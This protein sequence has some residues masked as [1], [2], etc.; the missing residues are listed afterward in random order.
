MS[1]YDQPRG[2]NLTPQE[3]YELL[4]ANP[5]ALEIRPDDL[6]NFFTKLPGHPRREERMRIARLYPGEQREQEIA[7]R[8]RVNDDIDQAFIA[9][10][11]ELEEVIQKVKTYCAE[12]QDGDEEAEMRLFKE[13]RLSE[14]YKYLRRNGYSHKELYT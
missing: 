9:L 4:E 8:S 3:R 2:D 7:E 10:G 12:E 11:F 5:N 1:D 6:N 14:V 13:L